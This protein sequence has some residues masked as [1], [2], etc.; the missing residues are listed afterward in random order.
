MKVSLF[1]V[2]R[3][4]Q[5]LSSITLRMS[6][7]ESEFV[8]KIVELRGKKERILTMKRKKLNREKEETED[9]IQQKDKDISED[10]ETYELQVNKSRI[11]VSKRVIESSQVWRDMAEFTDPK[12]DSPIDIPSFITKPMILDLVEMVEKDD[13]ECAHLGKL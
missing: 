2:F 12:D 10:Q 1:K 11:K 8:E 3:Y 4:L 5:N 6:L 13:M 7:S 9:G